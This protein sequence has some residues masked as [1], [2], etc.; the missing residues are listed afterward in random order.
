MSHFELMPNLVTPVAP[1]QS[2]HSWSTFLRISKFQRRID[3]AQS[4]HTWSSCPVISLLD[5]LPSRV[6]CGALAQSCHFLCSCPFMSLLELLSCLVTPGA[7][8]VS[9]G[10]LALSRQSWR[11]CLVMWQLV[12][13]PTNIYVSAAYCFSPVVSLLEPLLNVV[14]PGVSHDTPG[15]PAQSCHSWISCQVVLHLEPLPAYF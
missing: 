10:A 3:F 6:T 7:S 12:F 9:T 8:L 14:T 11:S 5:H 4:C 2:C 13:L 15:A 1:A